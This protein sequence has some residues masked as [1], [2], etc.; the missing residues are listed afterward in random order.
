VYSAVKYFLLW[1]G[2][3]PCKCLKSV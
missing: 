2:D 3:V 1:G